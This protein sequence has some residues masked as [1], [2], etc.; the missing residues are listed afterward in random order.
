MPSENKPTCAQVKDESLRQSCKDQRTQIF[1][2]TRVCIKRKLPDT[3]A[4][5][6]TQEF[7]S[8]KCKRTNWTQTSA[9]AQQFV[10]CENERTPNT[11]ASARLSGKEKRRSSN[12]RTHAK[13]CVE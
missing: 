5:A 2:S 8:I 6:Q 9:Q 11:S 12:I 13:V 1:V 10:M 4:Q 3:H 7:V